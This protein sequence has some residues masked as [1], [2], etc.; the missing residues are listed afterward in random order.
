[1]RRAW[2]APALIAGLMLGA[3]S[4]SGAAVT[5]HD[6]QCYKN[7]LASTSVSQ[8]VLKCPVGQVL[9]SWSVTDSAPM[10]TT[11]QPATTT[12]AG[13]GGCLA[14]GVGCA[15]DDEFNG[16]SV[17]TSKWGTNWLGPAGQ[18]TKPVNSEEA[19]C[20]DPAQVTEGGGYLTLTAV[21]RA[22]TDNQG[23]TWSWASGL[24]NTYG[25]FSF[26][27]G[28]M[29]ARVWLQG[30][31]QVDDW[32]AVWNSPAN[33]EV[34]VAEGLD[35]TLTWHY[36]PPAAG[37]GGSPAGTWTGWHTY[38]ETI[39]NGTVTYTWYG[40]TVC[41]TADVNG[42]GA[43]YL[44][45]NLGVKAGGTDVPATMKVDWVRISTP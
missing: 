26:T 17:D 11:T 9:G 16:S 18:I 19:S 12:T 43:R 13:S 32:P 36:H 41:S 14:T 44:I 22:C 33:L 21:Q 4:Q 35:G 45:I 10:S 25:K 39:E 8:T 24:V 31:S 3:W 40:K 20:Y 15:F 29:E 27:T 1:M 38:G 30:S 28:T 42:P 34:D 5:G 23:H 2:W 7:G 37:P 6:Y